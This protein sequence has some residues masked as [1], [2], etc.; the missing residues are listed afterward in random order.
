MC[1]CVFRPGTAPAPLSMDPHGQAL[2]PPLQGLGTSPPQTSYMAAAAAQQYGSA[3][4]GYPI[5][6]TTPHGVY[7]P[8]GYVPMEIQHLSQSV[9]IMCMHEQSPCL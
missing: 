8:R 1:L 9:S 6:P 7:T 3:P 4:G 5:M 2:V